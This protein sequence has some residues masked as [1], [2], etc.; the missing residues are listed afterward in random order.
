M[1]ISFD[2]DG[3]LF[4]SDP[5]RAGPP[6]FNFVERGKVALLRGESRELITALAERGW[7]IW[8]YT[9]SMRSRTSLLAWAMRLGMPV[10][11]AI[12]Q[13]V[14]ENRCAEMGHAPVQSAAK[15][16]Q[17]FGIDLH[18]DDSPEVARQISDCGGRVC[19]IAEDDPDWAEKVLFCADEITSRNI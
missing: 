13:Q 19:L 12:N 11:E 14:H 15:M 9:N 8:F 16:P 7:E 1:R 5:K 10:A 6:L 3:T 17:W 2:L 4:V 18:V